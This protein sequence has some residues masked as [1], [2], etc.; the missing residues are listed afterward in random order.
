MST[1]YMLAHQDTGLL[2]RSLGLTALERGVPLDDEDALEQIARTDL[3]APPT[4]GSAQ[5]SRLRL[6]DVAQ[7]AS[8]VSVSRVWG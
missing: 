4:S 8:K 7:A 5:A 6:D 2:Y 3:G 1:L